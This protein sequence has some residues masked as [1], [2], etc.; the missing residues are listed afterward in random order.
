LEHKIPEEL[1]SG[2]EVKLSHLKV[3]GCVS[4]VHISDHA[5]SKLDPKSVKCTFIGYGDDD[6]GYRFWDDQN[7]KV[8]RSRDVIFN[9][10]VM[11]KDRDTQS[12]SNSA[13]SDPVYVEL[14]DIPKSSVAQ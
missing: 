8:T 7:K 5:R 6:F 3:F 9:E 13:Q 2:K 14:D 12:P 1:W 11:Y 4:Y 10:N